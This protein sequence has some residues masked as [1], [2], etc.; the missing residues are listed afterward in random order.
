MDKIPEIVATSISKNIEDV[1]RIS[2]NTQNVNTV[3]FKALVDTPSSDSS[4]MSVGKSLDLSQGELRQTGRTL[5]LAV[6]G[7]GWLIF[8]KGNAITLT[9]NG[10]LQLDSRGFIT[11][12]N[13][14]RL[15][16]IDG[17][18]QLESTFVKIQR[19]GRV[20]FDERD[21]GQILLVKASDISAEQYQSGNIHFER[22]PRLDVD[23]A[24]RLLQGYLEQSNV[25]PSTEVIDLMSANR[26]IQTM[27]KSLAAYDQVIKKAISELGK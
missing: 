18:I 3:G 22:A 8:R 21:V 20:S 6:Q 9:R 2:T 25:D 23:E 7:D 5:D 10:Q 27:Q 1:S 12:N 26:H 14:Y 17:D 15:Q 4:S 19:D 11:G 13:G 16:G 24:S